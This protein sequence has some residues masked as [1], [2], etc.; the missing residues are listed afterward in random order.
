MIRSL[1]IGLI[2]IVITA[3]NVRS[4]PQT[5]KPDTRAHINGQ[6]VMEVL[7]NSSYNEL[8]QW[9]AAFRPDVAYALSPSQLMSLSTEKQLLFQPDPSYSVPEPTVLLREGQRFGFSFE[10]IELSA[11]EFLSS[12]RIEERVLFLDR[13][14][15][16]DYWLTNTLA[17]SEYIALL[18]R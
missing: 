16:L 18:D 3:C 1:W 7:Q 12:M 5:G 9:P 14:P 13:H 6:P 8:A 2:L 15:E 10:G 17:T 11:A 4:E